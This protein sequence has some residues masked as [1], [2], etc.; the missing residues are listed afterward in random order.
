V[1]WLFGNRGPQTES[2]EARAGDQWTVPEMR[3]SAG[4]GVREK[5]TLLNQQMNWLL[6]GFGDALSCLL[7]G[8][9]LIL[10]LLRFESFINSS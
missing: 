7:E 2:A 8:A 5:T 6:M 4:V 10:F 1:W 3:L 9:F